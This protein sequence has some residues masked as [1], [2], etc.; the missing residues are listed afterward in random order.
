MLNLDFR[1]GVKFCEVCLGV[2]HVAWRAMSMYAL[3]LETPVLYLRY[4]KHS[5][6]EITVLS[7]HI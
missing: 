2:L 4:Y 7:M 6:A 5:D 3:T 1:T